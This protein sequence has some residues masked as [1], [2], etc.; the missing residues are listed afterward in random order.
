MSPEELRNLARLA[1][2]EVRAEEEEQLLKQVARILE[3]VQRIQE[4]KIPEK[5]VLYF[6]P[7]TPR[8]RLREDRVL[9]TSFR[10]T[11]LQNAPAR[12]GGYLV[13]PPV[14]TEKPRD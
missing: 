10:E 4:L 7:N 12:W 13:V 8:R 5:K 1:R 6:Y 3:R 11:F 2:L 14:L 9:R